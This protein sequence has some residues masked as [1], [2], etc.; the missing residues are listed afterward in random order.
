MFKFRPY[1]KFAVDK[2]VKHLHDYPDAAPIL[3]APCA[4]GKSIML[5]GLCEVFAKTSTGMTLVITHR[6][7]LVEQNH[8]K[9]PQHMNAGVYSAGLK[10]KELHKIT[11]ASFQSIRK[12]A[13]K[14]PRVS[15]IMIDEAD[16]AQKGYKEFIDTVREHSPQLRIIG[17]TATPYLGDANR[18]ALHLLPADKQIFTSIGAE[19]PIGQLLADGYLSPLKPYRASAKIDTSNIKVD[20]RTGDFDQGDMQAAV[21]R[22]GVNVIVATEIQS[23]F[24]ERNAIMVFCA[25][26]AHAEHMRDE[27]R[28]LGEKAE[29]VLSTTSADDRKKHIKDFREGRLKYLLGVDVLLVGFDAPIMDGIAIVRPTLSARVHVQALGRGMRL[30]DGKDDCLVADFV[31]NTD[32]HGPIDEIEGNPPRTK[33]GEAPTKMCD[34]CYNI[35]LAGLRICPV[36]GEEFEFHAKASQTFDPN[37]GMLISGVIKNDDG[38]KTYPISE[39]QYEIRTTKTGA[40]ALVANYLV[41]GRKTPVAMDYY[42]LFHHNVSAAQRDAMRWLRRQANSGGTVPLTAQEALRRAEM[43]ALRT[44]KSVTVRQGS[45]FPVRMT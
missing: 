35:I 37:T 44:P 8:L 36:C 41:E 4:A 38:T 26:M 9:L 33:M 40:P 29:M 23:I 17:M 30:Y 5:A 12:I 32:V 18:T 13:A 21:D 7:E 24:S 19:I 42:N 45:P 2:I 14:L 11:F 43:G 28:T 39:V 25:G 27:L 6:Q 22:A 10:K 1:Q 15:Y 20:K 31:G 3:V 16:F 34:G